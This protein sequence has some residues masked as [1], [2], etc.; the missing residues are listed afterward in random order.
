MILI[1]VCTKPFLTFWTPEIKNK[2][3]HL[4]I[5]LLERKTRI[6]DQKQE[7]LEAVHRLRKSINDHLDILEGEL[8]DEIA[9]EN[10]TEKLK[11]VSLLS[12]TQAHTNKLSSLQ[13]DLSKMTKF[14]TNFQFSFLIGIFLDAPF[15]F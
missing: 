12:Q 15:Y 6:E 14:A 5:Y 2:M 10:K 4:E 7:C 13:N 3:E 1:T 11:M 8:T 9:A